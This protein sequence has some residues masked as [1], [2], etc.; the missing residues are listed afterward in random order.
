VSSITARFEAAV[1]TLVGD[2]PVKQRLAEAWARHLA[3]IDVADLPHPLAEDFLGLRAAMERVRPCGSESV[4]QASVRKMSPREAG[5]HA[6]TILVLFRELVRTS[7]RVEPLK[8]VSGDG[9]TPPRYLAGR[10]G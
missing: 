1:S 6:G 5:D 8:I 2:G 3:G 10:G 9:D 7:P 4:I